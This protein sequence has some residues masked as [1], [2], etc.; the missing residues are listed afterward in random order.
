LII[1]KVKKGKLLAMMADQR[2]L[3]LKTTITDIA[4]EVENDRR[5]NVKTLTQAHE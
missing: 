4:A 2:H 5:E 3:Y 1:K